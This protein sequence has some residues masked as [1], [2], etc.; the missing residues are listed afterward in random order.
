MDIVYIRDLKIETIIGIFDWEREIKQ[1][2]TID[3]EMGS[4]IQSA[5]ATD[6]IEHALDYNEVSKRLVAFVEESSFE[7]LEAMAESIAVILREEFSVPWLR[8]RLGKPG[9][10]KNAQDV[11]VIIERGSKT[12]DGAMKYVE[13]EA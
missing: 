7:L 8:L 4:N 3:L 12:D 2:V 5:A 11:G 10:I 13:G 1:M 6:R 9:A